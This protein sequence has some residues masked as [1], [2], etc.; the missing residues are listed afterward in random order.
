MH[1]VA[2]FSAERATI[3]CF[4]FRQPPR[5]F[6]HAQ[7][8][9]A[10]HFLVTNLMKLIGFVTWWIFW[11]NTVAT[12]GC[13][14]PLESTLIRTVGIDPY[15]ILHTVQ[16]KSNIRVLVIIFARSR[17][18]LARRSHAIA[19]ASLGNAQESL[20]IYHARSLMK[21]QA[22]FRT[23]CYS[24]CSKGRM[25]SMLHSARTKIIQ[26]PEIALFDRKLT[27]VNAT[28]WYGQVASK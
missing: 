17:D 1:Q 28:V 23:K 3:V 9:S 10:F 24:N 16:V 21:C 11:G 6:W 8:G 20:I 12:V 26:I 13:I 2:T 14:W 19:R 25:S 7:K 22:V 15:Y 18:K 5:K 27:N 4:N